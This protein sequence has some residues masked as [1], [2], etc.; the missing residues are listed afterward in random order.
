MSSTVTA[1]QHSTVAASEGQCPGPRIQ[2]AR[3]VTE[4]SQ[5][6]KWMH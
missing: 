2:A 4:K 6:Q 5:M 1:F 3:P